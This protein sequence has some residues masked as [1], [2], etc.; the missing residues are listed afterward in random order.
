MEG[1]KI[2]AA[3]VYSDLHGFSKLV[4]TQVENKS[5]V[6]LQAF[7]EMA[8]RFTKHY[9]GEVMGVA[10]DRVLTVFHRPL[11]DLSNEPVEDAV[12]YPLW[13]HAVFNQAIS[14]AFAGEGLGQLSLGVGIEYGVVV[15][16]C[17]GIRLNKRIVF[18]GVR[19]G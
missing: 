10:G 13:L 7:I 9:G 15:V 14:P 4:A 1:R 2:R 6:F 17:V 16:G 18:F 3:F 12:T 11:G 19:E 8:T 5:F